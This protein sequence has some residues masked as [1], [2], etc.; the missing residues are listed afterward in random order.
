[1]IFMH[2]ITANAAVWDPLLAELADEHHVIAIDQRG[3]GGTDRPAAEGD[4]YG[5][6]AFASDAISLIETVSE[7]P[8]VLV[9][10]SL[11]ARNAAVAG[12]MRPDLVRAVVAIDYTP[13]IEAE[14]LDALAARVA[15]GDRTFASTSDI[16]A[17][18]HE[19]YPL[20]PQ[21]ALERRAKHG[22]RPGADGLRPL[23]DAAAL[24]ATGQG[25]RESFE[26][27]FVGITVPTLLIR[28]ADSRLVSPQAWA[29]AKGL[30]PDLPAIEIP[31][32]D[33]YVPEEHPYG[34]VAAI[35]EFLAGV[36]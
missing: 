18:L 1:M 29:A 30:R 15:A 20:M 26:D 27:A 23:A 6:E 12:W 7:G 14:V 9:G 16:I 24:A 19:R 36:V 25:L 35:R 22:Y 10:H 17:Y 4:A 21:D 5:A 2:G 34:V 33:H 11:G 32:T 13:R 8:A 3:H 31:G 28:G